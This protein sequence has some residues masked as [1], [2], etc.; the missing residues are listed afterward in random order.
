MTL[1]CRDIK[2]SYIQLILCRIVLRVLTGNV[3]RRSVS[4]PRHPSFDQMRPSNVNR[5]HR[6]R[7]SF[8]TVLQAL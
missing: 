1:D 5:N 6:I 4:M 2:M 7:W 8:D 3:K